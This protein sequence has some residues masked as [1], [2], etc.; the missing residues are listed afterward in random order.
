MDNKN[1]SFTEWI[2]LDSNQ[3]QKLIH[4]W[5]PYEKDANE[6][7]QNAIVIGFKNE[8]RNYIDDFLIVGFGFFGWNVPC[9]YVIVKN[10]KIKLPQHFAGLSVNKGIIQEV[11]EDNKFV[12]KWRYGGSKN[13]M[14]IKNH[15]MKLLGLYKWRERK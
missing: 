13:L 2:N 7:I 9:I 3:R 11:L 14:E 6:K 10:S 5:N 1:Y 8:F 4:N 12:I 15:E